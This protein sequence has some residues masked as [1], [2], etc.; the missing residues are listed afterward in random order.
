MRT[1]VQETLLNGYLIPDD[2]LSGIGDIE[3]GLKYNFISKGPIVV[4]ASFLL[5]FPSGKNTGGQLEILQ[6]GDGEFN[7]QFQIDASHSFY[8][9]PFYATLSA[10]FNNRNTSTFKYSSGTPQEVE[11]SDELYWGG[12]IGWTPGKHWVVALKWL[13]LNS[14]QNGDTGGMTGASSLV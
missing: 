9:A 4:S 5:D 10:G 8:P 12:E 7:Q 6:T 3:V 2:Q 11:F 1:T 14:L 13:H